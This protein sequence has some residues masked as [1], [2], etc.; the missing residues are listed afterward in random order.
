[1]KKKII[2]IS[3]ALLLGVISYPIVDNY[4]KQDALLFMAKP[5]PEDHVFKFP[6]A[7]EEKTFPTPDGKALIHGLRMKVDNP[8]G[9]IVYYHGQGMNVETSGRVVS[10]LFNQR[11]YDVILADYRGF[12]KSTGS[13]DSTNFYEDALLPYEWAKSLY[14]EENITIYGCSLGT[15]VGA[16]V[17]SK[18]HPKALI[19]ESPYYNM[20]ELAK[21]LKPYLPLPLIKLI[22]KHPMRT[23]L[24]LETTT[25]PIYLL[26]GTHDELI[27]YTCSLKLQE[28]FGSSKD[29]DLTIIEG[30]EHNTITKT[31]G[32]HQKL[33]T[34]LQTT[35][36]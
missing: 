9:V 25:C 21:F 12:G 5:L 26:H 8:Q 34:I 4:V 27:P 35:G 24:F 33:D 6:V 7:F 23:D 22:L 18:T 15:S 13:V 20:I 16:Y 10:K 14:G 17:S 1:M 2:F 3:F 29:V 32:Y 28:K 30:A 19:L 11:G 31:L 36:P